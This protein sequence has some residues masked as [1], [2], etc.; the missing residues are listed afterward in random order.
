MHKKGRSRGEQLLMPPCLEDYVEKDSPVRLIDAFVDRLDLVKVGF[1]RAIAREEGRPP[2][3]P[4]DLLK[5]FIYGYMNG[6]PTSRRLEKQTQCNIEVKWLIGDLTPDFKTIARFRS[7]NAEAIER[8]FQLFVELGLKRQFFGR[9]LAVIDGSRFKGVNSIDKVYTKEKLEKTIERTKQ[10]LRDYIKQMEEADEQEEDPEKFTE[11]ELKEK[12][13]EME[14]DLED[15]QQGKKRLEESQESRISITDP[16]CR[17]MKINSKTIVGY[18]VQLAVDA[19]KKLIAAFQVTND[20]ADVNNLYKISKMTSQ[21]VANP[22]LDVLADSG[23]YDRDELRKCHEAGITTYISEPKKSYSKRFSKD[24][25]K[26]DPL[27]DQYQCPAGERLSFLRNMKKDPQRVLRAYGTK[28]CGGCTLRSQCTTSKS[29]RLIQRHPSEHLAEAMAERVKSRPRL[30][31]SRKA[32]IEHVFGCLKSAMNL[33]GFLTKG[34]RNVTAEFS[35]AAL[36]FNLKR[37]INEFGTQT[38]ITQLV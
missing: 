2:Y 33:G 14:R 26:Y 10:K 35:L 7:E 37:L 32:I 18:N 25:F 6:V 29:G 38:L 11:E 23:Y 31:R 13:A 28:S 15:L 22:R 1:K 20:R 4:S 9:L 16:D 27:S 8:V 12:I 5:L 19:H 36:A 21:T 34:F 30:M 3:D 24:R 17:L